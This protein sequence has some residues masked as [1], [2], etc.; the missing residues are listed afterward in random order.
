MIPEQMQ[1]LFA[2][3]EWAWQRVF[4]SLGKLPDKE[5][6][7]DRAAFWGSLHGLTVH[8]LAAEALWLLRCQYQSPTYILDPDDYPD[9]AAVRKHWATVS[10]DWRSFVAGLREADYGRVLDYRNTRGN[11]FSA[12]TVDVLQHVVNHATEHRSQMT[13][14]LHQLGVPTPP[15]DYMLF[16]V[17]P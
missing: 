1:K 14:L 3:N 8:C 5:Y 10:Q 11:G 15:L 13:P 9:L 16:C 12:P 2:Y 4:P 7:Q 6:K 17:H